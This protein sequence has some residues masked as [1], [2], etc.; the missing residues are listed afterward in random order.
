MSILSGARRGISC[1]ENAKEHV[2]H[3]QF[4]ETISAAISSLDSEE[5]LVDR[6]GY[7]DPVD[8]EESWQV[9]V[10]L[11]KEGCV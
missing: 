11:S 8:Q 5:G 1:T 2:L 9:F 4:H 3:N 7:D 10:D 6:E